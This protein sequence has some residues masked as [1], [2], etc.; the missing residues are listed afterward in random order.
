ML[1]GTSCADGICSTRSGLPRLQCG[2]AA[3]AGGF[4]DGSPSGAPPEAHVTTISSS[5][6]VIAEPWRIAGP[7]G[8]AYHGGSAS[9][10][11][12]YLMGCA[13]A[14]APPVASLL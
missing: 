5:R 7:L 11:S 4:F 13:H 2:V 9:L 12:I 8:S 6:E 3:G 14:Q 10:T 1:A